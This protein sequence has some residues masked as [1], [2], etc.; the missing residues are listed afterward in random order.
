MCS[1]AQRRR[2]ARRARG[3]NNRSA[4]TTIPTPATIKTACAFAASLL[5]PSLLHAQAQGQAQPAMQA[6]DADAKSRAACQEVKDAMED[7]ER[8]AAAARRKALGP[9]AQHEC[10]TLREAIQD[11]EEVEQRGARGLMD[12]IQQETL[13][14]RQRYREIGC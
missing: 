6:C 14:L 2:L 1:P 7:P 12:S 9:R 5:L 4:E 3:A 11:N 8:L 10:R 13:S